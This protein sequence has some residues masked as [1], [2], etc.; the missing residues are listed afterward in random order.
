MTRVKAGAGGLFAL[1]LAVLAFLTTLPALTQLGLRA[2]ESLV[3]VRSGGLTAV[4]EG[5]TG[6]AQEV[7]GLAALLIGLI[8]LVV[9]RR[10][11]DA[12]RLLAMAGAA[13]VAA[14]IVKPLLDRPRP[15]AWLWLVRPDPTGSFPS[16]HTTTAA[17]I[18][19]VCCVLFWR[20]R[21][22]RLV[23]V[24]GGLYALAVG[25]SR[26]YLGDHYPADVLGSYLTVA[27]V[28]LLVS[29]F[30]DLLFFRR[31]A[32]A[33]L[34]TP[35]ILPAQGGPAPGAHRKPRVVSERAS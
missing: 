22:G 21:A 16:G 15:P 20:T 8:V 11:F 18:V 2:D 35:E 14:I 30:A 25:A 24:L 31:I 32:A 17:V 26:L 23:V 6:A 1:L 10:R 33:V 4:A 28:A 34:R 13:W 9:W 5:L 7:V 19:V 29:A 3:D 12:L 27:A